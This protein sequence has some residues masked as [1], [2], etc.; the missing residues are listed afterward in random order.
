MRDPRTASPD[1]VPSGFRP[2][3]K[4]GLEECGVIQAH[5]PR[6]TPARG[7]VFFFVGLLP[8]LPYWLNPGLRRQGSKCHKDRG[9]SRT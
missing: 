9:C 4:V 3:S 2:A 5:L 6:Q 8:R 1:H 7:F